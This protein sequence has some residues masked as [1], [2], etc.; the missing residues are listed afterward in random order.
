M[1]KIEDTFLAPD[2][3]PLIDVV[4][5][6]LIFFIVSSVFK[7]DELVLDVDL[8]TMK[9]GQ[10][11]IKG[12]KVWNIEIKN[13]IYALNGEKLTLEMLDKKLLTFDK[14]SK[15]NIRG[16]KK[17]SYVK[18]IEV[19]SLLQRNKIVNISLITSASTPI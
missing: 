8:P 17:T 16:D 11:V 12:E 14:K 3:T 18:V 15:V 4:F 2:L 7:K 1:K 10:S 5:I 19:L 6:L 9:E 13:N